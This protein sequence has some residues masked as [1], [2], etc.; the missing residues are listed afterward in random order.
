[1]RWDGCGE[2]DQRRQPIT[3]NTEGLEFAG[4][5]WERLRP[6]WQIAAGLSGLGFNDARGQSDAAR[7]RCYGDDVGD[8]EALVQ[9]QIAT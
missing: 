3:L 5:G 2:P 6:A 9:Q 1:M 8:R 7:D 4:G